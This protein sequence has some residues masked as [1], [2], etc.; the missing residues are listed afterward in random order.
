MERNCTNCA[1]CERFKYSPKDKTEMMRCWQEPGVCDRA[2]VQSMNDAEDYVSFE[3][4]K[5]LKEKGFDEYCKSVYHFGSVCSVTSLGYNNNEGYGEVIDEKQNSDFGKYDNA[6]S[7][8]TLQMAMKWLREV[9]CIDIEV[10]THYLN[11]L[12]P[13]DTRYYSG[14]ILKGSEDVIYTIY[15][16]DTNEEVCE[17][18]IKYC[19]ENLI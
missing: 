18:A 16:K 11:Y 7:A 14:K 12:K 17:A 10:R 19:L 9:H 1:F 3:T 2:F 5:L 13:N 4:A 8:P 6:I 15:S